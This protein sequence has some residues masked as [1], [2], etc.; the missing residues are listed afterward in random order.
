MTSESLLLCDYIKGYLLYSKLKRKIYVFISSFKVTL[1]MLIETRFLKI[2][3]SIFSQTKK[4]G[5]K[6]AF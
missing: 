3:K 2:I 5:E 4:L 1:C 6:A